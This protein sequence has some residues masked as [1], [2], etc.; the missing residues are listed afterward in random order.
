MNLSLNASVLDLLVPINDNQNTCT[1]LGVM[2]A[3]K[4]LLP[5]IKDATNEDDVQNIA[6]DKLLQARNTH[7]IVEIICY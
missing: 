2:N 4:T 3:L 5:N 1:I 6:V 7:F